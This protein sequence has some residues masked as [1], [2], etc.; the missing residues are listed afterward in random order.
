[1]KITKEKIIA[2]IINLGVK[3]GD[4]LFVTADLLL[5]GLFIN[6]REETLKVWIEILKSA[7]GPNGTIIVAAYTDTFYIFK[8]NR[9]VIFNKESI[10]NSGSLSTAFLSYPDAIR[11]S[12]PTNSCFGFGPNAEMILTDHNE[13]SK[14]YSLIGKIIE[15]NGKNLMIGTVDKKNAPMAFHYAQECLGHTS[16][17]PLG[18]L[19]QTYYRDSNKKLQLFT[20][21]DIGGCSQGAYHL[22]GSLIVNGAVRFGQVGKAFSA[23]ID[24]K[25]SFE[26]VVDLLKENRKIVLCD[27]KYCINCYGRWGNNGIKIISFYFKILKTLFDKYIYKSIKVITLFN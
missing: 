2:D 23:L 3:P 13:Y 11:S 20:R 19:L 9:D 14:S 27:D 26:V 10:P 18:G 24:G 12:H 6:S 7:V 22:Y 8:K 25:K 1:M 16:N 21:Y 5:A 15:L 17:H 4:T